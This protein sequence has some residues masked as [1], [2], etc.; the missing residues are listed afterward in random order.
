MT[1]YAVYATVS[2]NSLNERQVY[3]V[4]PFESLE[5]A[6]CACT[7]SMNN[8]KEEERNEIKKAAV[9]SCISNGPI[10]SLNEELWNKNY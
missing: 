1:D 6:I 5:E 3:Q 8:L 9:Y 7:I 4:S 2:Y 10:I